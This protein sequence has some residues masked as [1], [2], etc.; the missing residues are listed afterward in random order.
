MTRECGES[1]LMRAQKRVKHGKGVELYP[2][3]FLACY[4]APKSLKKV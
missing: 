1:V 3:I 2:V 4:V